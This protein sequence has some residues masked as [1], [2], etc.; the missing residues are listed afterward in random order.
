MGTAHPMAVCARHWS[1]RAIWLRRLLNVLNLSTPLGL[2]L[3]FA[4][5]ARLQRGPHGLIFAFECPFLAAAASAMTVGDVVLVKPGCERVAA[6]P[7]M[8]DHEAR[9]SFQYAWLLGPL[10]F[11]PAYLLAS[12]WSLWR[13][14]HPALANIFEIRADLADG[15]YVEVCVDGDDAIG[16]RSA[17]S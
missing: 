7:A 14:G 12:A 1:P 2:A 10:G 17:E 15:G 3:A 8:V 9:H 16:R 6:S 13:T 4:A 5:R 11:F